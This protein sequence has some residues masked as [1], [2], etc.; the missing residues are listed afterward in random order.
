MKRYQ[1][2]GENSLGGV[3]GAWEMVCGWNIGGSW[4]PFG[5]WP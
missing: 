3:F 2:A 4:G 5:Y 1:G